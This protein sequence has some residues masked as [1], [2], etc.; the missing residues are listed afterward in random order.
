VV[1]D[2]SKPKVAAHLVSFADGTAELALQVLA[3]GKKLAAVRIDNLGGI[4]A[5]WRSDGQEGAAPLAVSLGGKNTAPGAPSLEVAAGEAELLLNLSLQD[6]GAFAGQATEFR[7][8]VFF[9]DGE[10]AMCFLK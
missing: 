6:N 7:V 3:P 8:T 1:A 5:L 2:D 9:A 4:R 10:R